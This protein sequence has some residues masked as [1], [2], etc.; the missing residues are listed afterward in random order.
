MRND[1]YGQ[2][3][4]YERIPL[5]EVAAGDLIRFTDSGMGVVSVHDGVVEVNNYGWGIQ[6]WTVQAMEERKMKAYRKVRKEVA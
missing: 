2:K 5:A 1:K 4:G 6:R 3:Y